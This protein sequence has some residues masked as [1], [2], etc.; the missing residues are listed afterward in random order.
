MVADSYAARSSSFVWAAW[1]VQ[2]VCASGLWLAERGTR[3]AFTISSNEKSA[4]CRI[5]YT[6]SRLG[7]R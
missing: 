2:L 5:T 3:A 7:S 1:Y 4:V 6:S